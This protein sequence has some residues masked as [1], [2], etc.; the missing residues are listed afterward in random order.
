MCDW[1]L[2]FT[3]P[4]ELEEKR[5]ELEEKEQMLREM[6]LRISESRAQTPAA[7]RLVNQNRDPIMMLE[8]PP[9]NYDEN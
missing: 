6:E 8:S 3:L 4:L 5:R 7:P 2:P 1:H 9:E